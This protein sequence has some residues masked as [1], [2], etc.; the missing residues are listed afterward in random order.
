MAVTL[1]T[2]ANEPFPS[3]LAQLTGLND[4]PNMDPPYIAMDNLV[5]FDKIPDIPT[6]SLNDDCSNEDIGFCSFTCNN[7][8]LAQDIVSCPVISQTFDDGP[9]PFYTMDLLNGLSPGQ[10]TTFFV[11]GIN[12]V[13]YGDVIRE[14]R[15]RGHL[16]ASH[17]WSHKDLPQLSNREVISQIQWSI[18][19]INATLGV[20][21]RYFRPPY[22]AIDNRIR[23]IVEMFG[24][25]TVLWDYDTL[26]WMVNVGERS[27]EQTITDFERW[28]RSASRGLILEHDI[29]GPSV[30]IGITLSQ[31]LGNNQLTVAEC[32]GEPWYQ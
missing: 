19:A 8:V 15:N 3:W 7:C 14:T 12:V 27:Q 13:N 17:T 22:G 28:K 9:S 31:Q 18:W 32:I 30:Q 20:V 29:G 26:D 1:K 2:S 23:A 16:I 4:W 6:R 11:Q 21:P 24:L 10:K 25:R 5:G